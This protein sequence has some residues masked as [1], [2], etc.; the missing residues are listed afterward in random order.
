L[1]DTRRS[2]Y[3]EADHTVDANRALDV[4]ATEVLSLWSG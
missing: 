4:V 2:R 1:L 3:A